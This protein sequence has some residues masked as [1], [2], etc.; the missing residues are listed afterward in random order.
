[1]CSVL[2]SLG[3]LGCPDV[4][5]PGLSRC[6]VSFHPRPC[7]AAVELVAVFSSSYLQGPTEKFLCL[8]LR[9]R[10]QQLTCAAMYDRVLVILISCRNSTLPALADY[11]IPFGSDGCKAEFF[12]CLSK[13]WEG[14]SRDMNPARDLI[15]LSH[16]LA[17]RQKPH[18]QSKQRKCN[19]V[20]SH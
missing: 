4:V 2:S 11:V 3:C 12:S 15:A 10:G 5:C 13:T 17:W 14:V 9:R 20:Y 19:N 16:G 8:S 7:S 18:Q 1:M 6:G